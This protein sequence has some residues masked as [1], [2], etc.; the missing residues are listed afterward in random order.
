MNVQRLSKPLL[1]GAIVLLMS[2]VPLGATQRAQA[3]PIPPAFVLSNL[4][5]LTITTPTSL[6]FG[7]DGRLYV[8]QVDG[9][10]QALTVQ[11]LGPN[12][13]TV[14]DV[15]LIDV[16]T[17]IPNHDDDGT[18]RPDLDGRLVTAIFVTGTATNPVIYVPSSD[19]RFYS[20]DLDTNSGTLSRLTWNGTAWDHLVLI[21]GLP[22]SRGDHVPNGMVLDEATNTLYL[23]MGGNANMGAPTPGTEGLRNMP[24]VA[25]SAAIL[26]IDLNTIGNTTFTLPTIDHDTADGIPTSSAENDANDPWGGRSGNNQARLQV[27]SPVQVYSPGYRNPFDVVVASNGLM[28]TIDNGPNGGFGGFVVDEQDVAGVPG[29]CL[30]TPNELGSETNWDQL[31]LVTPGFYGGHA[32]PTRGNGANLFNGQSP[33]D[34]ALINPVECDFRRSGTSSLPT[35]DGSLYQWASSTNGITEYT[36]SNFGGSMTGN[37]LTAAYAGWVDRIDLD[38]TGTAVDEVVTL[39]SGFGVNPLDVVAQGDFDIF[40]GTIW[41]TNFGSGTVTILEP[42]DYGGTPTG[43]CDGTDD[44]LLDEDGDGYTN[45]DEIDNGSSPCSAASTPADNDDDGISDLNDPDDDN[46]GLPDEIDAFAIDPNNGTTT[47]LP[48]F[49]TMEA[50]VPGTGFFGVGFTG[51][52]S[53][54][55]TNYEDLYDPNEMTVGAATGVFALDAVSEGTALGA[56]NDQEYAFQFGVGINSG[57]PPFTLKARLLPPLFDTVTL[58]DQRFGIYIGA[59]D[60]DNYL[61]FSLD[62]TGGFTVV[63]EAAGTPDIN[64]YTD[65]NALSSGYIDLY[66]SINPATGEVLPR[67]NLDDNVV[68]NLPMVTLGGSTLQALQG[69]HQV[70]GL[71][72][73]L[74]IGFIGTSN[75]PGTPYSAVWDF[76]EVTQDAPG[77]LAASPNPVNFSLIQAGQVDSRNVTLRNL[78]IGSDPTVQVNAISFDSSSFRLG[79]GVVLPFSLAPQ[80]TELIPV[81]FVPTGGGSATGVM[82]VRHGFGANLRETEVVL[83]GSSFAYGPPVYRVNAGGPLLDMPGSELD[84]SADTV[85]APSAYLDLT[86]IGNNTGAVASFTG[87]GVAGVPNA[88]FATERWHG[89]PDLGEPLPYRFPM[90]AAGEYEVRLY[91]AEIYYGLPGNGVGDRQFNVDINGQRVLTN[92]DLLAQHGNNGAVYRFPVLVT[93]PGETIDIELLHGPTENPKINGIEIVPVTRDTLLF[94]SPS[95]YNYGLVPVGTTETQSFTVFNSSPLGSAPIQLTGLSLG[96]TGIFEVR[97]SAPLPVNLSPGQT[98]TFEVDFSPLGAQNSVDRVALDYLV[99]GETRRLNT[100]V[101]GAGSVAAMALYRVNAGGPAVAAIEAGGLPWSADLS[102]N[103][104]GDSVAVGS[105]VGEP[106]AYFS[107]FADPLANP[108][109]ATAAS[110]FTGTNNTG[111]PSALF[112]TERWDP[113]GDNTLTYTFPVTPGQYQVRIYQAENVFTA[114]GARVFDMQIEGA[115][116]RADL[117]L[118]F[119]YMNTAVVFTYPVTVLDNDLE[120]TMLHGA[121]ENPKINAIE[122]LPVVTSEPGLLVTP[123]NRNFGNIYVGASAQQNFVLTYQGLGDPLP[124]QSVSITDDALNSF[125]LTFGG[126]VTL[127][128]LN[129][130]LL[131]PVVFT[132]NTNG[133]K[134]ANLTIEYGPLGDTEI[135]TIPLSGFGD[136]TLPLIASPNPVNFGLVPM[137]ST[138]NQPVTLTNGGSLGAPSIVVTDVSL[139]GANAGLFTENFTGPVTLDVGESVIFNT[140]FAPPDTVTKTVTLQVTYLDATATPTALNVTMQG[141]GTIELPSV[142]VNFQNDEASPEKGPFAPPPSGYVADWGEPYGQRTD[143]LQGSGIWNYGWVTEASV[144]ANLEPRVGLDL[145]ARG[146]NRETPSDPRLA[147]LVFMEHPNEPLAGAWEISLPN[148]TYQIEVGMGDATLSDPTAAYVLRAEGNILAEPFAPTVANPFQVLSAVVTVNDG[149]LTIDSVGGSNTKLNYIDIRPFGSGLENPAITGTVPTDGATGVPVN[150]EG[151]SATVFIP[152]PGD[153]VDGNSLNAT[154]ILFYQTSL[155]PVAGAVPAFYNTTGGGDAINITPT[156]TLAPNTNYTVEYTPGVTV[157]SGTP[158]EPYSFSFT[159]GALVSPGD[160]SGIQFTEV[161]AGAGPQGYTG[162]SMGPDGR[163]YAVSGFG[164]VHSWAIDPTTGLLS[165]ERVFGDLFAGRVLIGLD[166]DPNPPMASSMKLW[167]T[168]NQG[169]FSNADHF[170]GA[171]SAITSTDNGL[172]WTRQ[173]YIVGLPRSVRDHLSNSIDFGPDGALYSTR[174]ASTPWATA[175]TPGARSL[176]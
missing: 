123:S 78:G 65:T 150:L 139:V 142:N 140:S 19:P 44:P 58:D 111:A 74:A 49:Y 145:T 162:L 149:R 42:I 110:A 54:G 87:T 6:Q 83:N 174:A 118:F 75:G 167:V 77:E 138:F 113:P 144:V 130:A 101:R 116:V 90:P 81:E 70:G 30:N 82:T 128:T 102:R 64:F 56:S 156:I 143:F 154:S 20:M 105:P 164:T 125:S 161:N 28:Y 43:I 120:V 76:A 163:L 2:L 92:L 45:A 51:L 99:S 172:T 72:S 84:W 41:V 52:M 10:I 157:L 146:A 17:T 153:S 80:E 127:D 147:T 35:E 135:V 71:A 131:V 114:A 97:P 57:T 39:A 86:D 59:G 23:A 104:G 155:G 152:V 129:P 166:F 22:R 32:N 133:A 60:Q 37:L 66:F 121:A 68:I 26:S 61:E 47:N 11:R 7:P 151:V 122:V 171:L 159:T 91:F 25:L 8:A 63:Q 24:E 69:M 33:V 136:I 36:A 21:E 67:Y 108:D 165:D 103:T 29:V 3:D 119:E 31:H 53:N 100:T 9:V 148:G 12:Q 95:T 4:S 160:P 176:R 18:P 34:S 94:V 88:L 117:D 175:I 170:T 96:T 168:H 89:F 112:T 50:G 55:S 15:E 132:P 27:G 109:D 38:A 124:I 169:A 106:S 158:F 13:Y 98:Y 73:G 62:A 173:D 115:V 46:D 107:G 48:I 79:S 137:G 5:N 1:F 16:V 40:P 134:T 93:N 14:T 126:P 141:R 85:V